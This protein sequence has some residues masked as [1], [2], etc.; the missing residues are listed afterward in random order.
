MNKTNILS[1][2]DIHRDLGWNLFH[3][4]QNRTQFAR[5]IDPDLALQ[6]FVAVCELGS[7]GRQRNVNSLLL[8]RLAMPKP[9]ERRC[10]TATRGAST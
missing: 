9:A 8:L 10:S 3:I 2:I 4:H 6:L 5:R 7:I 1:K